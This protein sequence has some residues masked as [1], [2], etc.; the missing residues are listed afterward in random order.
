MGLMAW[1]IHPLISNREVRMAERLIFISSDNINEPYYKEEVVNFTYY[2]GFAIS[3]KQKSIRSLHENAL[4]KHKGQ[5]ILEISTKSENPL[6]VRLSAF[7]MCIT[8]KETGEKYP[9][10]NVFQS[11]K[12]YENGGPYRD[13]LLL[14]PQDAKRDTRHHTS[15]KLV[16]FSWKEWNC[17]LEPKTMFYDWIYC[18]AL[19]EDQILVDRVM[20]AGYTIF[21]DIE[22]NQNKSINCQA[23]A[24]A[25]FTSLYGRG[26]LQDFLNDKDKWESIYISEKK[27]ETTE[28]LKLD[29]F[30]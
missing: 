21:T 2:T 8:D 6:G 27:T 24:M 30:I 13:M 17:P 15:G 5:K 1:L 20:S 3:Q 25:I 26:Q 4:A 7:T 22:F 10:E 12:V 23:R 19:S 11:S 16:G 28:Q 14:A 9:L 29:L 18:K